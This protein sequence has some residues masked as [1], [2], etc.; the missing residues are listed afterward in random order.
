[1]KAE[2]LTIG[3]E[4]LIGSTINTNAAF[5]GQKLVECGIY[6]F[7]TTV[8]GDDSDAI[9]DA[10]QRAWGRATV[11]I[12]TGGLGP[13]H[14]DIT[15]SVIASFF[16]E[17]L[18]LNASLL[19]HTRDLFRRMG[20]DM[21]KSTENQGLI[22]ENCEILWNDLGSAAGMLFRRDGKACF[23]MP[24]VP[25]E[26]QRMMEK[27]VCP[28]LHSL[29]DGDVVL[30][31]TL[32][33][34]GIGESA[35]VERLSDLENILSLVELAFLPK[36]TGVEL[37]LTVRSRNASDASD[38]LVRAESMLRS[39]ISEWIYAFDSESMEQVIGQLLTARQQTVSVAESCTGG[40]IAHRLTNRAGSSVYFDS[41]VV[42]YSNHSK[43]AWLGVDPET[44]EKYGA[45][46]EQTARL[47]AEGIR[48][49]TGTHF[50][51]STT[52]IAGPDG[53]T[54]E[55]PVG[56]VF[57]AVAGPERTVHEMYTFRG[58]RSANK[59]RFAQAALDLLRK[60]ILQVSN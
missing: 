40:L 16:G 15:K 4:I 5:I 17:K 53:G 48:K 7:W 25:F 12:V 29:N 32:K 51:V 44:I 45:V 2:I 19:D 47:M 21:P 23:V 30:M 34:C 26:M 54:P 55:K 57:V 10:L 31:R 36:P 38:R 24:G 49:H 6:P 27:S 13:T 28:T 33:T 1:M 35:I 59:D 42:S 9:L 58:D 14:D 39:Q 22:P 50:G 46:S 37:R 60:E 18:V 41:G 43:C 56:R 52:G 3:D 11:V 8:V 20:R